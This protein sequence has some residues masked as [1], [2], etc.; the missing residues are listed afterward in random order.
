MLKKDSLREESS[1]SDLSQ[2]SQKK[3]NADMSVDVD[4]SHCA[5]RRATIVWPEGLE[6]DE[7]KKV[8]G[9]VL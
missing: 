7:R 2:F 3:G 9:E 1:L 5:A 6:E 4:K 8:I